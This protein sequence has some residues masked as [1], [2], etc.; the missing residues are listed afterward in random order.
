MG[1]KEWE[2]FCGHKYGWANT[3]INYSSD[4]KSPIKIQF[5]DVIITYIFQNFLEIKAY[6][7]NFTLITKSNIL[8]LL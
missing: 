4:E 3:T 8:N 1:Q 6:A 7:I 5:S 2:V